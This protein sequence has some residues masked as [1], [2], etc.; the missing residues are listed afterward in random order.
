MTPA[1]R[2]ILFAAVAGCAIEA[3][4]T[5]LPPPGTLDLEGL[6]TAVPGAP[7]SYTVSGAAPGARVA[8]A[9]STA[10]SG[11]PVCPPPLGG[12]CMELLGGY[13]LLGMRTADASGS[14]TFTLNVPSTVSGMAFIEAVAIGGGSVDT[15]GSMQI[16]F[17]DGDEDLDG[18]SL[19]NFD[20]AS[21]HGTNWERVDTDGGGFNDYVEAVVS[22]TDPT[23]PSDDFT[24][25]WDCDGMPTGVGVGECAPDFALR[26][27]NNTIRRLS[28][29]RGQVVFLDFSAMWCPFCRN[30][31]NDTPS[32]LDPYAFDGVEMITVLYENQSSSDPTQAD[33][34]NWASAYNVDHPLLRDVNSNVRDVWGGFGQPQLAIIDRDG[35]V[36][37]RNSGYPGASTVRSQI[38]NAVN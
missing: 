21:I 14:A 33:L 35:R 2:F 23:D 1:A 24:A 6:S 28:E 38:G 31:A 18:D 4:D 19:S 26:D 5:Q 11:A 32:I 22:G 9:G 27:V 20:E 16:D 13:R 17:I 10:T 3:A 25:T 29:F 8:L 37:W 34:A 36:T 15:S 30:L 12:V 7:V